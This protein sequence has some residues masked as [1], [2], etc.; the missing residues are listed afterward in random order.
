MII[1]SRELTIR[2]V[3]IITIFA[4]ATLKG[5]F[6]SDDPTWNAVTATIGFQ[7]MLNVSLVTTCILSLK[8]YLDTF[9]T[10]FL[11]KMGEGYD[12]FSK[13]PNDS[14]LKSFSSAAAGTSRLRGDNNW[15]GYNAS[16]KQNKLERSESVKGLTDGVILQTLQYSVDYNSADNGDKRSPDEISTAPSLEDERRI[17]HSSTPSG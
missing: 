17:R 4:L 7:V 9:R 8:R 6:P 2:R 11:A 12:Q 1:L 3:P 5:V 14:K 13:S 15:I 16:S 10:G